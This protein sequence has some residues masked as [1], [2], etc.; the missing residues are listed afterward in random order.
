MNDLSLDSKDKILTKRRASRFFAVQA[1]YQCEHGDQSFEKVLLDFHQNHLMNKEHASA[2]KGDA[3]FFEEVV[4]GVHEHLESIDACITPFLN[5]GWTLDRLDAVLRHT[6]RCG[7]FELVFC[8][9]TP[10]PI[11]IFEYVEVGKHFFAQ[12]E[13][14][15]LN[16]LLDK[17]AKE[18]RSV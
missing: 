16:A 3:S 18:K 6:L 11:I 13:V 14:M 2:Q 8:P 10:T 5:E 1:L 7:V 9:H 12:G 17:I 15:F 4:R